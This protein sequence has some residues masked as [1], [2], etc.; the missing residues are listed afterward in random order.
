MLQLNE[1]LTIRGEKL[2]ALWSLCFAH[3]DAFTLCTAVWTHANNDALRQAL[4]PHR[5]RSF[6]TVRW[7]CH[8]SIE[9]FLEVNVYPVNEETRC[10]VVQYVTDLWFDLSR[11]RGLHTLEDLCFFC[12][13][14]LF[15]G[16]VSHEQ[17]CIALPPTQEFEK[18]LWNFGMWSNC[19]H[20]FARIDL[21]EYGEV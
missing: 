20:P 12:D 1:D 19:A 14:Q 4:A 13:N 16:T 17:I 3:A 15:F 5:I 18:N 21:S 7:F 11:N 10:I 6:R 2:A 9:P 8:Y